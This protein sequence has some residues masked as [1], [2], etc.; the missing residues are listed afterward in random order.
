MTAK[1]E[2]IVY[3]TLA[4]NKTLSFDNLHLKV[5][6]YLHG[7]VIHP[8]GHIMTI[9]YVEFIVISPSFLLIL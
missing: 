2:Q 1:P 6:H 9:I 7:K 3:H 8:S 4:N 5:I